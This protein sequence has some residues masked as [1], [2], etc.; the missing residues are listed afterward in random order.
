VRK[1]RNE[2]YL[3]RLV[4]AAMFFSAGAAAQETQVLVIP[5][6]DGIVGRCRARERQQ[7]GD[8]DADDFVLSQTTVLTGATITGLVTTS[9][10]NISNVEIGDLSH[11]SRRIRC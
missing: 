9:L 1:L 7:T 6:T 11:V 3:Q 8:G 2:S 4:L 5:D 10:A